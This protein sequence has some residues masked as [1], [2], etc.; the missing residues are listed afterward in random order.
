MHRNATKC[1]KT[2]RKW[3][4][5]KHGASKIIDTFETYQGAMVALSQSVLDSMV[6]TLANYA[7]TKEAW[8]AIREM[9]VGEDKVKRSHAQVLKR[10]FSKLEMYRGETVAEYSMKITN[11]VSEIKSLGGSVTDIEV[12]E[13]LFSSVTNKFTGIIGTIEQFSNITKMTIPEVIVSA[14]PNLFFPVSFPD[15]SLLVLVLIFLSS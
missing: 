10:Q 15:V 3:C 4:I 9:C 14:P 11:L 2:Q 7:T 13:K 6:M 12:V 5:N 1:N 8:E